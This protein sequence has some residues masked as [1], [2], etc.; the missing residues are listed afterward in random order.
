MLS[1]LDIKTEK[2]IKSRKRRELIMKF[3]IF[4]LLVLFLIM[5]YVTR[6]FMIYEHTYRI[7]FSILT[8]FLFLLSWY[9]IRHMDKYIRYT[10]YLS[11]KS[12]I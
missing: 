10:K 6:Y 2:N 3:E 5:G 11:E 8:I 4:L 1:I 12:W 9:E 7:A